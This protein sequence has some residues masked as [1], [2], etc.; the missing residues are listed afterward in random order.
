M[1]SFAH[2]P[3]TEADL[4]RFF[5]LPAEL[6]EKII[7][8]IVTPVKGMRYSRGLRG[9][10]PAVALMLTCRQMYAESKGLFWSNS[11]WVDHM[12]LGAVR[13]IGPTNRKLRKEQRIS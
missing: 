4:F 5:K 8:L 7:K 1:D 2:S 6:R 3:Y 13:K 10:N 11:F 12:D 9:N